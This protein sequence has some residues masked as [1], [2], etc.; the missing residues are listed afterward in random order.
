MLTQLGSLAGLLH[1]TVRGPLL[2]ICLALFA[3]VSDPALA[4]SYEPVFLHVSRIQLWL[5]VD[6]ERG[7][8]RLIDADRLSDRVVG[9]L[10]EELAEQRSD[11]AVERALGF[12]SPELHEIDR[13]TLA[14]VL[15]L[16]VREGI[17][18]LADERCCFGALDLRIDRDVFRRR[19]MAEL[20]YSEDRYR[21]NW[22][23]EPL[24]L[25]DEGALAGDRAFE[26]SRAVLQL[27]VDILNQIP[28]TE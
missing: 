1:T 9:F 28:P 23:P 7:T 10:A 2:S 27:L 14:V 19:E 5:V 20:I 21:M 26:G 13:N 22:P 16:T 6:A 17:V 4:T 15:S 25:G 24:Y 11:I 8:E 18:G 12:A 3:F